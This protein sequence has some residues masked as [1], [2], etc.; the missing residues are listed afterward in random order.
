MKALICLLL[1]PFVASTQ[2]IDSAIAKIMWEAQ[3]EGFSGVVLAADKG[4]PVYF[5]GFGYRDFARKTPLLKDDIFEL[6]SVSKQFTA[7][8]IMMLRQEGRLTFDDPV[9]KYLTLPYKGITIR[10]LLT[11]TS[12]L[13]DY[14]AIMDK[15]WDKS[16]VASNK[17]ILEYLNRHAPPALFGPG[18]K[19]E[20]SNTGYV[21]LA[22]I[23][24][25]ASGRDFIEFCQTRI[26]QPLGMSSTAI[27]SL[28]QKAA[29]P[30]F[31]LGHIYVA[32]KGRYIRAD[33]FPSSDYT[34][35]L[36]NRKGP[37][38]ISST[39]EDLLKWDQALYGESIIS[40]KSRHE[41]FRPT[42]LNNG[43]KSYYGFG[44]ELTGDKKRRGVVQHTGDNPGYS[45]K[46]V[47]FTRDNRTLIVLCNNAFRGYITLLS[48]LETLMLN[49]D[50]FIKN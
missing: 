42:H 39:A 16:Q 35:W 47:R 8:V 22:S 9:E 27:R 37:G 12:G 44:W 32:D 13:P 26:F 1:F 20:Y 33:S 30:N 14:Q 45:T 46:I 34:I 7:A 29:T 21:L 41:A 24:E 18:E 15:Y 10:H 28:Q 17:E 2:G 11:H 5:E 48:A 19:Y 36:G 4:R 23:A 50:L 31:A 49:D 3:R 38:R 43:Q 25:K 6:A 40:A